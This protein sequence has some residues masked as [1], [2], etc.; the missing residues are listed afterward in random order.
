MKVSIITVAWNSNQTIRRT[1]DSVMAQTYNDIEYIII[2]GGSTDGTVETIKSYGKQIAQFIHEPDEGIYDAMNKGINLATGDVIGIL[3]SDDHF[4]DENILKQ[5]ADKFQSSSA[6]VILTNVC[7]LSTAGKASRNYKAF[8]LNKRIMRFG[9]APP[10]PGAF[11]AREVYYRVGLYDASFKI[12][13]DFDFFL[14]IL[15]GS[16]KIELLNIKSVNM[17]EGGVSTNGMKSYYQSAKELYRALKKNG[18]YTNYFFIFLRLPLKF[19]LQKVF[20]K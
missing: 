19:F 3:N 9:F 17:L 7:M 1:I 16:E 8:N 15:L 2:D 6:S 20:K 11:V 5:V 18:I 10:H 4:F 13:A 12:S 14:R